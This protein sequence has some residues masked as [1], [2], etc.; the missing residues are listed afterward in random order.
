MNSII[1]LPQRP[2]PMYKQP[3]TCLNVAYILWKKL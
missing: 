2:V 1:S 3:C